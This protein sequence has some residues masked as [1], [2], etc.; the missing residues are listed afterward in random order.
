MSTPPD[1]QEERQASTAPR[2]PGVPVIPYASEPRRPWYASTWLIVLYSAFFLAVFCII[3]FIP[4][5]DTAKDMFQRPGPRS[6]PTATPLA[7]ASPTSTAPVADTVPACVIIW[8][9]HPADDLGKKSRARVWEQFVSAEVKAAGMTHREFYDLVVEHN[10]Q[11]I[12][13]DYEFKKGKKY[14]LP[15]CQ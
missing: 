2:T 1:P 14:L 15:A 11:L 7:A 13:D 3:G 6:L 9:E 10:P 8:V 5:I 12:Q 4:Y